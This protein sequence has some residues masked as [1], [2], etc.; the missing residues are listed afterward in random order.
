MISLDNGWFIEYNPKP[1]PSRF[2]VDWD[3]W[4]DAHDSSD[5]PDGLCGVA[6]SAE[7]AKEQIK[8]IEAEHI[9]F[10]DK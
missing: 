7:A 6:A 10:R 8:D 4:H 5:G 2:G 3:F 9:Y 1:I